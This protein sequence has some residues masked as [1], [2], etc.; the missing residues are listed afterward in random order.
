MMFLKFC[1]FCVIIIL[2]VGVN[3]VLSADQQS[4]KQFQPV[5]LNDKSIPDWQLNAPI[6]QIQK[7]DELMKENDEEKPMEIRTATGGLINTI[8]I[9]LTLFAF[10]GNAMFLVY[11]FWYSK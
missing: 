1:F 6:E 7:I 8:M 5:I 10:V 4:D 11:V 3:L 9:T 2:V